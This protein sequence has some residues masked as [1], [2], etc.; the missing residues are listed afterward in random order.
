MLVKYSKIISLLLL[1]VLSLAF[2][3]PGMAD[4]CDHNWIDTYTG[5]TLLLYTTTN[6]GHVFRYYKLMVC[7][8]CGAHTYVSANDSSYPD[9]IY[10]HD[11][12][13]NR[14][15]DLGHVENTNLHRF[16]YKCSASYCPHTTIRTVPCD[17]GCAHYVFKKQPVIE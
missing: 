4:S 9:V 17:L 13:S 5:Y 1:I 7:S 14:F 10:P 3:M 6:N 2:F 16:V 11:F 8:L 12:S 15:A